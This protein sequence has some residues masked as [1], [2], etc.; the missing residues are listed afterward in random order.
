M[1]SR[2]GQECL[3]SHKYPIP[4]SLHLRFSQF[5]VKIILTIQGVLVLKILDEFIMWFFTIGKMGMVY[6]GY[7]EI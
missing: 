4:S 2:E 7:G 6:G 5:N 3:S 1:V